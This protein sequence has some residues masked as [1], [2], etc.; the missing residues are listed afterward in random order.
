[1]VVLLS[2]SGK[3]LS[4]SE[5]LSSKRGAWRNIISQS[6]VTESQAIDVQDDTVKNPRV[7]MLLEDGVTYNKYTD[8]SSVPI[9]TPGKNKVK[10]KKK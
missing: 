2:K 6:R 9:Y 7:V 3:V 1:M 5:L 8:G 10:A 4:T